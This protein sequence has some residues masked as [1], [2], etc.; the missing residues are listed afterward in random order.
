MERYQVSNGAVS[1][2]YVLNHSTSPA[3]QSQSPTLDY[4]WP[5]FSGLKH[6]FNP[7]LNLQL[8]DVNTH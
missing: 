2:A 6:S 7:M 4:P 5:R 3:S 1:Q 8:L